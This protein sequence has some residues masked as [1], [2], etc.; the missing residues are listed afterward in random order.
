[1]LLFIQKE[2]V[3]TILTIDRTECKEI[4]EPDYEID[5]Q[6]NRL[7]AASAMKKADKLG[8]Q[9][10]LKEARDTLK[11]AQFRILSSPSSNN[12]YCQQLV[13]GLFE[14]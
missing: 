13:K 11:S 3:S 1:M 8:K 9:R 14:E 12:E 10:K 7:N 6:K 2:E 5:L 4:C